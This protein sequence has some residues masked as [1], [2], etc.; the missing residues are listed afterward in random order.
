MPLT[1]PLVVPIPGQIPFSAVVVSN[2]L[3]APSCETAR[4]R[5][6]EMAGGGRQRKS[7]TGFSQLHLGTLNIPGGRAGQPSMNRNVHIARSKLLKL[8][9]NIL[10]DSESCSFSDWI[11]NVLDHV[12][13]SFRASFKA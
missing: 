11:Q 10:L 2:L 7:R 5:V 13:L 8:S 6:R 1:Y 3:I 12:S 9:L 4:E